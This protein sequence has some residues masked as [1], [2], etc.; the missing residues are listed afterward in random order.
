MR[1]QG[2]KMREMRADAVHASPVAGVIRVVT[3]PWG[4]RTFLRVYC[5]AIAMAAF[6]SFTGA[7]GTGVFDT[8]TRVGYWL[9][10]MLAGTVAMQVVSA[11]M[12]RFVRLEPL[13]EAIMQFVLAT[14]VILVVV[15]AV[16][17]VFS[18][19]PL[20]MGRLPG[21]ALP[22]V[23]VTAAMSVLHYLLNRTPRQT[24]VFTPQT[25]TEPGKALRERLPFKYRHAQLYAL[26]AE[27]H[28]LR[29]HTSAGET[30]ILMRLYD[31]IAE[32]DGIEGAQV[33]RSWWVAKDAV[34]NVARSD[35]RVSL[36]LKSKADV[37]VSR[38]YV[39]ALKAAGWF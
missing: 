37:P 8:G 29:V 33:H 14:P 25:Y 22:V 7:L 39:Q 31:A 27:D 19:R 9:S 30:L 4:E 35:G 2:E 6:L 21:Y 3:A 13:P 16:S 12:E 1:E 5:I 28:Y 34:A 15:W 23:G 24:H 17:A 18:G 10:V 32:L 26:S 20:D 36:A 11:V 38:S